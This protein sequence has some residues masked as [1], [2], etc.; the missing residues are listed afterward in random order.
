MKAKAFYEAFGLNVRGEGRGLALY[1]Q[2]HGHCWGRLSEG[3]RKKLHYLSFGALC[4]DFVNTLLGWALNGCRRRPAS[5]ATAFG[6]TIRT[7]FQSKFASPRNP[8]PTKNQCSLPRRWEPVCAA[9][10]DAAVRR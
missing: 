2:G 5:K 7:A 9:R 6:F 1:T 8:R 10:W 4:R 3:P